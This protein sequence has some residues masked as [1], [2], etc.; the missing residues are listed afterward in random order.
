M[1]INRPNNFWRVEQPNFNLNDINT[2]KT[3]SANDTGS[4]LSKKQLP[5]GFIES[6]NQWEANDKKRDKN[7]VRWHQSRIPLKY[8]IK[9]GN[10]ILGFLDDFEKIIPSCFDCW[11]R[12]SLGKIRFIKTITESDANIVVNWSETVVLGRDYE[13]GHN[14]LKVM[15]NRIE[16]ADISIVVYPLIDKLSPAVNRVER[17]RRTM[18]HELGHSLGLQHS[19]S[20]RDIMFHRGISNKNISENDSKEIIE[21]Y[22]QPEVNEFKF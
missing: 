14:N 7:K 9:R 16:K 6:L 13:S 10:N 8:Y 18:L 4:I 17:V 5:E 12:A 19:L 22:N 1:N 11:S 20:S 3:L 21:L 15:G 2:K